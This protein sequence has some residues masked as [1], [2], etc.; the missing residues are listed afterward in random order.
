MLKQTV[1]VF[2]DS[3]FSDVSSSLVSLT[4]MI[5]KVD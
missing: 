3:S 1:T 5:C 2:V 4:N